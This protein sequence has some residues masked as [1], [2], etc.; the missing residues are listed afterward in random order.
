MASGERDSV[1]RFGRAP[2]LRLRSEA[3]AKLVQKPWNIS[4]EELM[5]WFSGDE[6][7]LKNHVRQVTG[8]DLEPGNGSWPAILHSNQD[9]VFG[10]S[11]YP[12]KISQTKRCELDPR[13]ST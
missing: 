11:A 4:M 2:E 9:P 10:S 8:V 3:C 6:L 1:Q 13:W 5:M 7:L 12:K